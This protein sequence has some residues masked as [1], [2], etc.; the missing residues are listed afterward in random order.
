MAILGAFALS[1]Q[2]YGAE[3]QTYHNSSKLP[4]I[5]LNAYTHHPQLKSLQAGNLG[6]RESIIQARAAT[7]PQV[8]LTGGIAAARRDAILRSGAP[9]KQ[10][11]EPRDLALRV[12][13]TIFDGGRN[14]LLQENASLELQI[15]Q[16]RYEEAA[17][18]IAAEI[19]DDYLQLMSAMADVEILDKS[20][21]TLEDFETSVLA[22]REVG[23]S[24]KTEVAQAASRIAS[25]RAQ[26]AAAKAALILA[27]DQLLSKTGYLIQ[28]PELPAHAT[29]EIAFSKDELTERARALNP[30]VK[31]S[32]LA[33]QNSLITLHNEKRRYLPTI[34]LSAQAQTMRDSSPTIDQ[35]DSV[36]I[37]VNFTAPLYSGGANSS[38]TRQAMAEQNAAKFNTMNVIREGDLAIHQLWSRLESGKISLQAQDAN[39][40]AN[41]EALEGITR[42]EAVGLASTQDVLEAIQNKLTAELTYSRAQFDLY[43]TRL[44]LKLYIG[45]FD[46]H[47]FD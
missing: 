9:F 12:D 17:T 35:D 13:Q 7:R 36:R 47:T 16:A 8:S 31:A 41:V 24:T 20:V 2:T 34:S 40:E 27:R 43:T 18:A 39:V 42:G 11:N 46:V 38:R 45:Q 25:A 5:I 29:I 22:R 4:D 30:A 19:I 6:A 21:M 1:L 10:N 28:T 14:R 33:E 26:R 37:G 44:L 32:R 23:D 15:S 3:A